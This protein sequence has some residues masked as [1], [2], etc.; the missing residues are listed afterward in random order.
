MNNILN[1]NNG[2]NA[3]ANQKKKMKDEEEREEGERGEKLLRRRS[4]FH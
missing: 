1:E 4:V 3:I 2:S